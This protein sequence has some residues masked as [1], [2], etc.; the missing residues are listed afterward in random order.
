MY[1]SHVTADI[2]ASLPLPILDLGGTGSRNGVLAFRG[3]LRLGSGVLLSSFGNDG[4]AEARLLDE[5]KGCKRHAISCQD[6]V[7]P[8]GVLGGAGL[9]HHHAVVQVACDVV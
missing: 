1:L 8:G 5:G 3:A 4:L 6:E 9:R 7:R 2:A